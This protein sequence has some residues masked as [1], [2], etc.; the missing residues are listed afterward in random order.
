MMRST[1]NTFKWR[2]CCLDGLAWMAYPGG[3]TE[4]GIRSLGRWNPQALAGCYLTSL[5]WP[6]LKTM[7]G[8]LPERGYF[9]IIRAA[10]APPQVLQ[11]RI[12]TWVDYFK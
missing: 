8:F 6:V 4:G 9:H 10:V 2:K 5:P 1:K 7:A 12:F 11:C 3:G